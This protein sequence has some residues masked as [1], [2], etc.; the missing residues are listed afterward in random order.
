MAQEDVSVRE[1]V[2]RIKRGEIRLPE[3]QR[4][5][6][7]RKTQVRDLLDSLYRGYPS[8]TI[9]T[10]KTVEDVVTRDFSIAQKPSEQQ[11]FQ[12]LLDG[13]Q[14]LTSLSA[15][16]RG[17]PV[18]VRGLK[19]PI[20]ILFNLN[21]PDNL[22]E[23][24]EVFENAEDDV[25][26]ADPDESTA[27]ASEDD[28]LKRFDRMAFVVHSNKLA[29]KRHWVSVTEFFKESNNT[30][31]LK[32]AGVKS[33]DDPLHNVYDERLKRLR[34]IENYEYRVHILDHDK[35]HE[36]ATEIFV[37]V[38]SLGAKLRSSDLALAQITAKWKNSLQIFQNFEQECAKAID[39]GNLGL[40]I[41]IRN[42]VA[43]ASGQARFKAVGGLPKEQLEEAW[44]DAKKGMR[45]ALNFLHSNAG[46]DSLA[47]LSSPFIAV[48]LAAYG[49]S[50][51]YQ[52]SPDENDRLRHWVLA[53]SA[54]GRYSKGSSETL[55]DQDLAAV[56]RGQGIDGLLQNLRTQV[57]R[58]D[59]QP[60]D[61]ENRS[62][63][64]A[65]FKT[66]FMA[67]RE[68]GAG[69]WRDQ[70]IISLKHSG[71]QHRLQFHHI[72]PQAVLRKKNLPKEKINDICNL[73]FISGSTNRRISDK[74]PSVYLPEVVEKNGEDA[75]VKQC[76]P[77]NPALWRVDAY[78]MFLDERRD[79]IADRLDRF[80]GRE[81]DGGNE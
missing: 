17:E 23:V 68:D 45:F 34:A 18:Q 70:L 15:I 7:W 1:L 76:I 80:L 75:L 69:D 44:G 58:L 54:K 22:E 3:M 40:A 57:G 11:H 35:S 31:F 71:A 62:I 30:P 47:L 6:V 25:D 65:Y 8:G 21:H 66:M 48:T 12:L 56:R 53:A 20:D 55:L 64:S 5:Y 63:R 59:V 50:K 29:S 24:T 14:R 19:R 28:L 73:V 72:F 41:Q 37:R 27:D 39:L 26:D 42:L 79:L 4:Q 74:E 81:G 32:K 38:N 46:V 9:L 36:E 61:L 13:Q 16:L 49:H 77:T 67:F 33:F 52:L 51:K 43:F 78:D 10:W 2:A 60:E